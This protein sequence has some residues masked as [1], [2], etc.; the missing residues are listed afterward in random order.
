MNYNIKQIFIIQVI[1]FVLS[2]ILVAVGSITF[3]SVQQV[4]SR[5]ITDFHHDLEIATAQ[6]NYKCSMSRENIHA[7]SS[8]SMIRNELYKWHKMEIT[9][10]EVKEFSQ[11]KYVDGASVYANL[12]YAYR[13]DLQDNIIAKYENEP[14]PKHI[15]EYDKFYFDEDGYYLI[16]R[17][18][19]LS[20]SE[21]IGYDTAAF[22]IG[23]FT[24][25]KSELFQTTRIQD[26]PERNDSI[27]NYS[28]TLPIGENGC[29]VY[30]KLNQQYLKSEIIN[31][32]ISI[33]IHS[34]LIIL[35]VIVVSYLTILKLTYRLVQELTDS[36]LIDPLTNL[37]NRKALWES[38]AETLS[39]SSRY[40][41][42][43]ALLY[44]DID[45]FKPVNDTYGHATG[46]QIL[47]MISLRLLDTVR[48]SDTVFRIGGDEFV[49][50]ISQI[51][52]NSHAC[53]I[54]EK[55][56]KSLS[57][58]YEID[59][60][61]IKIGASIGISISNPDKIE[62]VDRLISMADSAMYE[63][64]NSGKNNYKIYSE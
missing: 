1:I 18:E 19:I 54:A 23:N 6:F 49:V 44:I 60:L 13:K 28:V 3:F 61:K 32:I 59:A 25:G 48:T 8:R 40:R 7:I 56:H 30:A 11:S 26:F 29:Y 21:L 42:T 34:L 22:R 50:L 43:F 35:V 5:V 46:D 57:D 12:I 64:K 16:L 55:I 38:T 14:I 4:E 41:F 37:A 33:L 52:K 27:R 47:K 20:N 15:P 63:V 31:R 9:L 24:R 10:D 51:E 2:I 58:S 17:S 45:G 39:K 36:S 53:L 62:T